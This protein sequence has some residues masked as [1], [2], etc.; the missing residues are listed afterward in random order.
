MRSR[1]VTEAAIAVRA[2]VGTLRVALEQTLSA[3]LDVSRA[4]ESQVRGLE[5]VLDNAARSAS[6]LDAARTS[7]SGDHRLELY[8]LGDRAHRIAARRGVAVQTAEVRRFVADV[9]ERVEG[10]R[11]HGVVRFGYDVRV[12]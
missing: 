6:A 2:S 8:A 11:R 9:A 5:S 3:A 7:Q 1:A 4:A 10:G 12:L